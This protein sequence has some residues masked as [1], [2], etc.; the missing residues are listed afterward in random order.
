MGFA[1]SRASGKWQGRYRDADGKVRSVGTFSHKKQAERAAERE[2]AQQRKPGAVNLDGTNTTWSQ[3]FDQWHSSR[4]L[5]HST[6]TEHR[7]TAKNHIKPYW[8][9][10]RL[11]K[12]D[13]L[14]LSRWVKQLDQSGASPYTIRNAIVLM[15][16]SLKAAVD[17]NRLASNP[18]TG[19]RGP[20]LP[21]GIERYLTRD[22]VERI[23]FYMNG[24]DAVILWVAVLTGLRFGELA[25]LHWHRVDLENGYIYVMEKYDQKANVIDPLPKDKDGRWV[26]LDAKAWTLLGEHYQRA[27]PGE[28][29]GLHHKAGRCRSDLVFRGSRGAVLK[30]NDWGRGPFQAALQQA[31][32][33]DRVRVHDLR[34]TYGSWLGQQGLSS[35][36][37]AE[38]MGHADP[39]TTRGYVH[40][41]SASHDRVRNALSGTSGSS[42]ASANDDPA[43]S[44]DTRN[45]AGIKRVSAPRDT[46]LYAVTDD[47]AS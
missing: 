29:C 23:A 5:S 16:A 6:D 30:S 27:T 41:G 40:R 34:H 17:D 19:L 39:V 8:G 13:K 4:V 31:G 33:T 37:I 38:M 28:T 44:T 2:E 18:A 35:D 25:G 47:D 14:G 11:S 22:E 10:T 1:V 15:K 45:G 43:R 3:W 20:D 42:A 9:R 7:S 21:R 26:P 12:I 36:D 46:R 24:N 32:I